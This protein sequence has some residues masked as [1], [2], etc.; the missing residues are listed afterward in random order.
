MRNDLGYT[1]AISIEFLGPLQWYRMSSPDQNPDPNPHP[2]SAPGTSAALP[3]RRGWGSLKDLNGYQWFVFIVC[4]L[5]WDMDCMD[6]QLFA[7]ARRPAMQSFITKM[8]DDDPRLEAA[9]R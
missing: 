3:P 1:S 7:L 2:V 8:T 6:Q 5:A 4:C 9:P